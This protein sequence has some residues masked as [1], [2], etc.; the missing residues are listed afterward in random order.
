M[1]T[2]LMSTQ[3]GAFEGVV[4]YDL[5]AKTVVEVYIHASYMRYRA[6]TKCIH[7]K[8]AYAICMLWHNYDIVYLMCL[9]L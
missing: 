2:G 1:Y 7:Y 8:Y 6:H 3:D 4:K 5:L 9:L